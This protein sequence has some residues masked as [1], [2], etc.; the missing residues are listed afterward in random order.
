MTTPETA[1]T[2]ARETPEWKAIRQDLW[3]VDDIS[4][5]DATAIADAIYNAV[6]RRLP[7][8]QASKGGEPAPAVD[9]RAW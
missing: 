6:N 2:A 7:E 8:P 1:R 9:G 5:R 3:M 4:T